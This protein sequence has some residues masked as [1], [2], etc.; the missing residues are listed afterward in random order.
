[1]VFLLGLGELAEDGDPFLL[2]LRRVIDDL[3]EEE[4]EKFLLSIEVHREVF[5][6]TLE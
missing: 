1:M 2:S 5:Q 4:V 3:V 6:V